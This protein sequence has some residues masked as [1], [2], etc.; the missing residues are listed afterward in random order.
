MD[1]LYFI[2][3]S[4]PR[5]NGSWF[6]ETDRD[7]NSRKFALNEVRR[8][9]VV[10]VLEINEDEGTCRD[11]TEELRAECGHPED[12]CTKLTGEDRALW[13]ADCQRNHGVS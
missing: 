8:G 4:S 11:V 7:S 3:T 9:G 13:E 10:K 1:T 12:Y 2:E 6:L 5:I